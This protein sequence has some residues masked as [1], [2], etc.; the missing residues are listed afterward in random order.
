MA[1]DKGWGGSWTP[2]TVNADTLENL[3]DL[4]GP[5]PSPG[6]KWVMVNLADG[7]FK[8]FVSR[9]FPRKQPTFRKRGKR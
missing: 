4:A 3:R 1:E 6:K 9:S 5:A 8:W 2:M 7:E